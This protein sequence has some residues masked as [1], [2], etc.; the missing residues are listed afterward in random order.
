MMKKNITKSVGGCARRGSALLVALLIMGVLMTLSLGM[1]S[2]VIREIR[3]TADLVAAGKAYYAAEAGIENALYDL[4]TNLPGY[5]TVDSENV[6]PGWVV[7][8]G[9]EDEGTGDF[10]YRY[11]ISNKG[12]SMPYFS[13]DEPI[14]LTQDGWVSR[15]TL[16]EEF[17]EKTYNVLPLNGSVTI[18]LFVADENGGAVGVEDFLIQYYVD[19]KIDDQFLS[20]KLSEWT[21]TERKGI[22]SKFDVL[23]WKVFGNPN[24]GDQSKTEAIS[25]FFPA[26][27][28]A[29]AGSPVCIGSDVSMAASDKYYGSCV[30]PVDVSKLSDV[31]RTQL[32]DGSISVELTEKLIDVPGWSYA[33]ECY[34]TDSGTGVIGTDVRDGIKKECTIKSFIDNHQRNYVTLTN[35]INPEIVGITNTDLRDSRANI[36]WRIIAK[37][38][39]TEPKLVRQSADIKAD[40]FAGGGKVQQSIDAKVGMSSFLPVFNFSLYRTDTENSDFSPAG[41]ASENLDL[42]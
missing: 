2:L 37:K 29:D 24:S 9:N 4:A 11:M 1:S 39:E 33:R 12:D 38:G 30:L 19:F 17:P 34:L 13:D 18:P 7:V 25:D 3:Q 22:I 40:G 23:R 5:E 27:G 35:L 10:T 6:A 42:L 15:D 31:T 8:E 16:F 28:L 36:Y 21:D 20:G 26:S 32:A 14:F 41:N